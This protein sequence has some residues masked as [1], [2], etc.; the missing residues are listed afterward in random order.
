MD[1]CGIAPLKYNSKIH[2]DTTMKTDILNKYFTSVFTQDT[3]ALPLPIQGPPFPDISPIAKNCDGV[4][5]LLTTLGVHKATG[6]DHIPS[7]LL[8]EISSEIA[9]SLT[10]IFQASPHQCS[11][12]SN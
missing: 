2:D 3:A 8:K 7:R 9:P 1:H 12:P 4:A 6:P 5:Q 10:L 11:I